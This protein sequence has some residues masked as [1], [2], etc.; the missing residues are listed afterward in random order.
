[1]MEELDP[2]S[3]SGVLRPL[4]LFWIT[5]QSDS[6]PDIAPMVTL[7]GLTHLPVRMIIAINPR[8]KTY[9][10]IARNPELVANI[11]FGDTETLDTLWDS[12]WGGFRQE[13]DKFST[14]GIE[15]I[16]SRAVR[17]PRVKNCIASVE[18]RVLEVLSPSPSAGT[19]RPVMVLEP[20]ACSVNMDY[21]DKES[22]K[23][24]TGTPIPLHHGG[25]RFSVLD[26]SIIAGRE[27]REA[28]RV[29]IGKEYLSY[30]SSDDA[31][32]ASKN[33]L[34]RLGRGGS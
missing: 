15:T 30:I 24:R 16:P 34:Q 13:D 8:R 29:L 21:Y 26:K 9:R 18:M 12:A 31:T 14:L 7:T 6:G 27:L 4:P 2:R 1:M 25:N 22:R 32:F 17:P 5:T 19:D 23:Y 11:P 3:F 20:V 33:L 10:N 28:G